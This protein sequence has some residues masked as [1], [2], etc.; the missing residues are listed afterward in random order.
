LSRNVMFAHEKAKNRKDARD[1]LVSEGPPRTKFNWGEVPNIQLVQGKKLGLVGLGENGI[2]VAMAAHGV[3]M[4]ILYYQRH[5]TSVDREKLVDAQYIPSLRQ[6]VQEADFTSIHVPYGPPTEK[7]FNL[8]ILSS[9]NPSSFLISTSRGGIVDEEA[10]YKV[11][12][13]KRIAG[14]A[15]DVYRWEPVPSDCPLLALN[16]ILWTTHNA[17]G[18]GEFI[19]QENRDVLANIARVERGDSPEF[20]IESV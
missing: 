18:A 16:N 3:G 9:M 12:S 17:G 1:G 2:E 6:L 7:M 19:L 20:L 13:E 5:R 14:A 10:L 8:E 4:K 11:L 15:L